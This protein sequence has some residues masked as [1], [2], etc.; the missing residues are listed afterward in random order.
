VKYDDASWHSGGQFPVGSPKEYGGTHIAL[1]LK[2]C[3]LKGWAGDLHLSENPADVALVKSGKKSATE[4]LF[5]RCDG[6]FTAEDLSQSG[7]AFISEYYGKNG[8]YLNDYGTTFRTLMYVAP[9]GAH[10]FK[11][12]SDMVEARYKAYKKASGPWWKL[13]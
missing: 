10:D 9:E 13:W 5:Q 7:N 11:L 12:F 4:F 8:K 1:L 3:F 2:W 6:K